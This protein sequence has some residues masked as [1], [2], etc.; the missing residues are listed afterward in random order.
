MA[1]NL[2]ISFEHG[3][4]QIQPSTA[5]ISQMDSKTNYS[6]RFVAAYEMAKIVLNITLANISQVSTLL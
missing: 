2:D 1:A 4:L 5:D 3:A 6:S